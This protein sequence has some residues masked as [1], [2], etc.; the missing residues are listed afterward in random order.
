[1]PPSA[2]CPRRL[3]APRL[4]VRS[5]GGT[6]RRHRARLVMSQG[7]LIKT[8]ADARL[9]AVLCASAYYFWRRGILGTIV[10]G[11]AVYLPAAYRPGLVSY[12]AATPPTMR[13]DF[14]RHQPCIILRFSDLCANSQ[15]RKRAFIRADLTCR[16]T[17][18]GRITEDT[19]IR[20][21]VPCVRWR[22][23]PA[24]PSWSPAT[25]AA[26]PKAVQAETRWRPSPGAWPSCSA[27]KCRWLPTGSM[28]CRCN[29]ARWCCWRTAASMSA[30]NNPDLARKM[31][32]LCDIYVNDAFGTA[33]RAE[34]TTHGIAEY[35]Q[36]GCAGPLLAAEIDA[37]QTALANPKRPAGTIVAGSKVSTKLTILQSLARRWT[38]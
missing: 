11:M 17:T 32:A 33:H 6:G 38:A 35:A 24:P 25:W 7:A 31:A 4:E 9:P 27:A 13:R 34:G 22:W 12:K 28:A 23:M 30:K 18:P 19:R 36:D 1:M 3:A 15:A 5:A 20:A 2:I 26:R 14:P 37:I 16:R 21:S 8:L 29:P 10:V